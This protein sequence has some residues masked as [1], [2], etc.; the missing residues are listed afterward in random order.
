MGIEFVDVPSGRLRVRTGGSQGRAVVF[1]VDPPNVLEHYGPLFVRLRAHRLLAFEPPGFGH[2][3]AA[4][5]Y[6]HTLDESA[7]AVVQLLEKKGVRDAVLAFPCLAAYAALRV[8]HERPDLVAGLVLMQA[9]SWPQERA[10]VER[11]DRHGLLRTPLVGQAMMA[12]RT[13][14]IAEAWYRAAV[15]DERQRETFRSMAVEAMDHG[16]KFPLA[17][18][19]QGLF[20][21]ADPALPAPRQPTLCLWGDGDR[22]HG[23]SDPASMREHAPQATHVTFEGCGHFPELEMPN[24]F[25]DELA[26]WMRGHGL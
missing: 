22:S 4:R 20:G 16:A 19:L 8:A 6:R 25:A 11:V 7:A 24:R 12:L 5:G 10:W 17:S 13:D 18:A 21:G 1:A 26:A 2:S 15:P 3:R 9:P 14:P 23:R